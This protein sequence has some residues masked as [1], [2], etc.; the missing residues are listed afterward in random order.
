MSNILVQSQIYATVNDTWTISDSLGVQH[1]RV[2]YNISVIFWHAQNR[3]EERAHS[4]SSSAVWTIWDDAN[5]TFSVLF[6]LPPSYRLT[7]MPRAEI[8]RLAHVKYADKYTYQ[9]VRRGNGVRA[10]SS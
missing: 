8:C 3:L 4:R 7:H 1:Q 6:L 9:V 5:T 2:S 10:G